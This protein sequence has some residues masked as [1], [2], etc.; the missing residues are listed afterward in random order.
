M[1]YQINV[2]SSSIFLKNFLLNDLSSKFFKLTN[3]K[4]TC[5]L[6]KNDNNDAK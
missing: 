4:F 5:I 6:F 2:I 1:M 3:F